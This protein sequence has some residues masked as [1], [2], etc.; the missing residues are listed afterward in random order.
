MSIEESIVR[1][2]AINAFKDIVTKLSQNVVEDLIFPLY[3]KQFDTAWFS[4]KVS[5]C[6]LLD[7]IMPLVS[8]ENKL[9]LLEKSITLSSDDMPLVRRA[10]INSIANCLK[11]IYESNFMLDEE[12]EEE[13]KSFSELITDKNAFF[14]FKKFIPQINQITNDEDDSIRIT[15]LEELEK[16]FEILVPS[17]TKE[18]QKQFLLPIIMKLLSDRSWKIRAIGPYIIPKFVVQ[19]RNEDLEKFCMD[20]FIDY[21]DD[22]ETE[23]KVRATFNISN[24]VESITE[25]KGKNL[26]SKYFQKSIYL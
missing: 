10:N 4:K 25:E 6:S 8:N 20:K 26:L 5:A 1:T 22:M 23:V 9:L 24:F 3:F 16:I 21:L 14:V 15:I 2:E 7:F 12:L 17:F 18:G 19:F 13:Y 11:I